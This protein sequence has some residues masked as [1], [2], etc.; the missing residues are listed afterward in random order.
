[1]PLLSLAEVAGQAS[2]SFSTTADN[3]GLKCNVKLPLW[4]LFFF[5]FHDLM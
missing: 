4:L 1:M 3:V 5:F 2:D